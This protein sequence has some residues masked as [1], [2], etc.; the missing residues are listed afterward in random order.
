MELN[1]TL[2]E[3]VI[4]T[5]P[6]VVL[7]F[8][9][10]GYLYF[11]LSGFQINI[12]ELN[13]DTSSIFIY[14]FSPIYILI[15]S[16]WIIVLLVI[17]CLAALILIIGVCFS[18]AW[19]HFCGLLRQLPIALRILGSAV[20]FIFFLVALIPFLKWAAF[21]Q[22]LQIWDSNATVIPIVEPSSIQQSANRELSWRDNYIKSYNACSDQG[23]LIQ[24]FSDD[25]VYFLLCKSVENT[26]EADVFE[27]RREGGLKSVRFVS[28]SGG[29]R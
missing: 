23:T 16:H 17:A 10:W 8:V 5:L 20:L 25:K 26:N 4:A 7:Y 19:H 3:F 1:K 2:Y 29:Q 14:A 6:A 12:G 28:R 11:L 18:R 9:G 15:T 27:V 22:K 24:I 13:F 21:R